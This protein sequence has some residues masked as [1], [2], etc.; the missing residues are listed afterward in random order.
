MISTGRTSCK[1]QK[2]FVVANKYL[3]QRKLLGAILLACI[4][5]VRVILGPSTLPRTMGRSTEMDMTP[6][7]DKITAATSSASLYDN[8][9]NT[10][11]PGKTPKAGD[12]A[13]KDKQNETCQTTPK[14]ANIGI[15]TVTVGSQASVDLSNMHPPRCVQN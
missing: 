4:K 1:F 11:T 13:K 6:G 8:V 15:G 2:D 12:L 3:L 7:R 9:N 10:A 5:F 14:T